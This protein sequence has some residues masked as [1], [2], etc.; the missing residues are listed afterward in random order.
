MFDAY[1]KRTGVKAQMIAWTEP[2]LSVVSGRWYGPPGA[3]IEREG[4]GPNSWLLCCPGCGEV[5]S[6]RE[7]AAWTAT[8]GSFEDVTTLSLSPSILKSC[9]GWHGHLVNGVFVA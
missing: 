1:S 2:P 9:C 3:F 5:G 8:A 7:G 4:T 6:P